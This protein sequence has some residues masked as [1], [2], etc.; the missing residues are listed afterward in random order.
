MKTITSSVFTTALSDK[1]RQ[2]R[3]VAE[4]MP[5]IKKIA[6]RKMPI[7]FIDNNI[8]A[9][10]AHAKELFQAMIPL[11]TWW[12]ASASINIAQDN[13]TLRLLKESRC[14]QLLIGYEIDADSA[15]QKKEGKFALAKDYVPLTRKLQKAN[16]LIQGQFIFGFPGDS[17]ASL[18]RLWW[19]CFRL[20]PAYTIVSFL[21]P[22]PG[23]RFFEE[24]IREEKL[25]NLNWRSYDLMRQ[26]VET[27]RL[28]SSWILQNAFTPISLLLL[29]T[30]SFAGR[31][32]IALVVIMEIIYYHIGK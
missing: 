30:T 24:S 27:P 20:S 7:T 32:L 29:F 12:A 28:K 22:L 13:E 26:V 14:C 4:V 31:I 10:P 15:M 8:Y 1:N 23:S 6:D 2:K 21:T 3:S 18:V 11:K 16:I 5:L 25:L 19:F 9:D 17:W